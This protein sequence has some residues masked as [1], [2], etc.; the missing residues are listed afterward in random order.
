MRWCLRHWH[1]CCLRRVMVLLPMALLLSP[2]GVLATVFPFSQ[3]PA[4]QQVLECVY[5]RPEAC[6]SALA[7]LQLL[8][9]CVQEDALGIAD[10][11]SSW[12]D[13]F[14]GLAC[15]ADLAGDAALVCH[16]LSGGCSRSSRGHDVAVETVDC[17]VTTCVHFS[18]VSPRSCS[19][20]LEV[21][22]PYRFEACDIRTMCWALE[23]PPCAADANLKPF[24]GW[25]RGAT[26]AEA[27]DGDRSSGGGWLP[28]LGFGLASAV[29]CLACTLLFLRGCCCQRHRVHYTSV[30][31]ACRV[32]ATGEVERT[33]RSGFKSDQLQYTSIGGA[34]AASTGYADG[35]CDQLEEPAPIT[36][37]RQLPP[38]PGA[39]VITTDEL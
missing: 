24:S 22:S 20:T 35:G 18:R 36:V 2:S 8:S 17:Q 33:A 27:R 39:Q 5:S 21:R 26:G 14:A 23:E 37:G 38:L 15:G 9:R 29:I 6:D 7:R 34:G 3:G 1:R 31:G 10:M 16:G 4:L 13:P 30:N 11:S 25:E 12:G 28:L 32:S 19:V